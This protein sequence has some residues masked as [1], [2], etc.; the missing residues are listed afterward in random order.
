MHKSRLA[1]FIIDC[2]TDDLAAAAALWGAAIGMAP[3]ALPGDEGERYVERVAASDQLHVEVQ[4]VRHPSRVHR[5]VETDDIEPEVQPMGA[6]GA[7]RV[8]QIKTWWV[9][10][11][12]TG[13]RFC[14]VRNRSAQFSEVAH[15]WA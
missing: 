3:R 6:I 8:R 7:M 5:N 15:V 10:E 13:Q 4:A 14:V 12:P 1:C 11:A 9:R 2:Q